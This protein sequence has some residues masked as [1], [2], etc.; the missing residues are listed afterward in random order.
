[1]FLKLIIYY[2][3]L[4]PVCLPKKEVTIIQYH[5]QE[6]LKLLL[7]CSSSRDVDYNV[8]TTDHFI[9]KNNV[10]VLCLISLHVASRIY[11]FL[12]N[13]LFHFLIKY[14]LDTY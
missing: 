4:T 3:G 8:C 7:V 9:K 6:R 14:Q 5:P 13:R 10:N 12:L 1:M 11:N 2:N